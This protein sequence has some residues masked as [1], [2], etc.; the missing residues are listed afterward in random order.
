MGLEN[1]MASIKLA[2]NIKSQMTENLTYL[3]PTTIDEL[4]Q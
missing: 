2:T 3:H 1:T 4:N